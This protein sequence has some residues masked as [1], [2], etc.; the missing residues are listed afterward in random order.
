MEP[1]VVGLLARQAI[2]EQLHRYCRGIDRMDAELTR[3]VWH[4]DGTADYGGL[5]RGSASGFV[6]WLWPVHA[7]MV[8][9]RHEVSNILIEL[10]GERA[11]SETYVFVTL[12][13]S[14]P[15]GSMTDIVGQGRYLDQ[16]DCR[17]GVW[18]IAHRD[19]IS[20]LSHT[21]VVEQRDVSRHLPPAGGAATRRTSRRD[22]SDHS[23]A[24]LEGRSLPG[25]DR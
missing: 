16:W 13:T 17:D 20:D 4:P 8:G 11:F 7:A 3:S 6:D 23:Y 10:D 2:T 14:E 1:A 19:Y 25:G 21:Y 5:Y 15:D 12:R 22:R 24:V 9:H 18:A